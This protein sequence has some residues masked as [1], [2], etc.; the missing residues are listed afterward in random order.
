[1]NKNLKIALFIVCLIA[2][3]VLP[4]FPNFFPLTAIAL[5]SGAFL[6]FGGILI[7]AALLVTA[8]FLSDLILGFHESQVAVYLALML[9]VF[10]G[11]SVKGNGK[12][13][14]DEMPSKTSYIGRSLFASSMF[15]LITNFSVW[16]FSTMYEKSVAG[17]A[18]CFT[19]AIPFFERSLVADTAFSCVVVALYS[20][21]TQIFFEK[22]KAHI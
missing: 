19:M 4:H 7:T 12:N 17:L 8:T 14:A 6:N 22:K 9:A 2:I 10:I 20:L 3:R 11:N 16:C 5:F 21:S 13:N 1:M 18:T 15:F